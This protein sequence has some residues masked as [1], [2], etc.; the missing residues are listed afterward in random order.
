[1]D[2]IGAEYVQKSWGG[3]N[4]IIWWGYKQEG[5]KLYLW[6]IQSK[7]VIEMIIKNK[8]YYPNIEKSKGYGE[9]KL[10]YPTLLESFNILNGSSFKGLI[11]G[12]YKINGGKAFESIQD[13]Y[14]YLYQNPA[15]SEGFNFWTAD[16]VILQI[17]VENNTNIMPIDFNDVI[18]LCIGKT[19]DIERIFTLYKSIDSIGDFNADIYNVIT[20]MNRGKINPYTLHKSFIEGHYPYLEIKSILGVYPNL[21]FLT[22]VKKHDVKLFDLPSKSEELKELI[23]I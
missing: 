4:E 8:K 7:E 9:M 11:F 5:T 19:N 22:S 14:N 3:L 21:D 16:Y 15:V 18:K 17:R 20:Y 12:F 6:T 2:S 23:R 10:V 1:M 13:V